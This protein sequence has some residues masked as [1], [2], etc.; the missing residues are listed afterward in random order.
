M[1]K[2]TDSLTNPTIT[3]IELSMDT[4]LPLGGMEFRQ[5]TKNNRQLYHLSEYYN[6]II[7]DGVSIGVVDTYT[8]TVGSH[9][10][11]YIMKDNTKIFENQFRNL[12][13]IE[14]VVLPDTVTRIEEM[15]FHGCSVL[16][17]IVIPDSVTWVEEYAFDCCYRLKTV[18]LSIAMRV[19]GSCMFSNCSSLETV[20][21]TDSLTIID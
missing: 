5:G 20:T 7:I 16:T 4:N 21:I 15:A 6:D 9:T 11:E 3:T 18:K 1:K 13:Y 17:S 12:N 2:K 19:I 14:K 8:F 10:I